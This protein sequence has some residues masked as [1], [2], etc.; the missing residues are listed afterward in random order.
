MFVACFGGLELAGR[1]FM[2]IPPLPPPFVHHPETG[3]ALPPGLNTQTDGF[4]LRTNALGLRGHELSSHPD[5]F[6]ALVL[7]DSTVYGWMVHE[8][9]TLSARLERHIGAY[10][11]ADVQNGGLPG[12]TCP[13]SAK[14]YQRISQEST[15]DLLVIYSL[16]SDMRPATG[17]DRPMADPLFQPLGLVGIGRIAAASSVH[18]RAASNRALSGVGLYERCLT[19]LL[20][21]Q[22][23][24]GGHAVLAVPLTERAIELAIAN[25]PLEPS[26]PQQDYVEVLERLSRELGAPLVDINDAVMDKGLDPRILLMDEVHPTARGNQLIA[27]ELFAVVQREGWL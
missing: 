2:P 25:D 18:L 10:R 22:Q 20:S 5:T 1:L 19:D 14:I 3:W 16:V 12:F 6:R 17:S 24:Q 9:E 21:E 15:I 7:G 4:E 27:D 11:R 8:E 26:D 23:R 13:Q